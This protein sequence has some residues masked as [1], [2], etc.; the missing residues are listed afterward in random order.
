MGNI[1]EDAA[2]NL[3]APFITK[4]LTSDRKQAARFYREPL[5]H[6]AYRLVL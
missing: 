4:P 6:Q 3:T 1:E 5:K 2:K